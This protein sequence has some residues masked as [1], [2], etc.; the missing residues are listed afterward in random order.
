[1]LIIVKACGVKLFH[2]LS[3]IVTLQQ[4]EAHDFAALRRFILLVPQCNVICT[5][6]QFT[7]STAMANV[8]ESA[9][10]Y[11]YSVKDNGQSKS[12]GLNACANNNLWTVLKYALH[13]SQP[14][15]A[16]TTLIA[17]PT[18]LFGALIAWHSLFP[19]DWTIGHQPCLRHWVFFVKHDTGLYD[20]GCLQ[21]FSMPSHGLTRRN[22]CT[23]VRV[24]PTHY[25]FVFYAD[26]HSSASALLSVPRELALLTKAGI[27]SSA[28]DM[29]DDKDFS[30]CK[31][32]VVD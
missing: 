14:H 19:E 2:K 11:L 30:Y 32:N 10:P 15:S 22:Y 25:P 12:A 3:T 28:I 18:T 16:V 24:L 29:G 4:H 8:R 5:D 23:N 21:R 31:S 17:L 26:A 13:P 27:W 6:W 9:L 1:M 7:L 20:N